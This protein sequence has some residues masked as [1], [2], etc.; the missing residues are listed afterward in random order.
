MVFM[1]GF[2]LICY[3]LAAEQVLACPRFHRPPK[4]H[5]KCAFSMGYHNN[6]SNAGLPWVPPT[7]ST[8]MHRTLN[9]GPQREWSRSQR[10]KY[11]RRT[12]D[13]SHVPSS[14]KSRRRLSSVAL[15]RAVERSEQHCT[16]VVARRARFSFLLLS[17]EAQLHRNHHLHRRTIRQAQMED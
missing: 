8:A 14:R 11:A 16:P 10:C 15:R 17:A 9:T 13:I 5:P 6:G 4:C 1:L 7:R 12:S 2:T 3:Q